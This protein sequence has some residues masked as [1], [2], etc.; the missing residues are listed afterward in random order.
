[1]DGIPYPVKMK[2]ISKF[3]KKH[4]GLVINVFALEKSNN[5]NTLYPAYI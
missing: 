5:P 2:D 4:P 3:E 1:M